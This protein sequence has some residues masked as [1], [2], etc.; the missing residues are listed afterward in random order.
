M[1]NAAEVIIRAVLVSNLG[2]L[3]RSRD[4]CWAGKDVFCLEEVVVVSGVGGVRVFVIR[5]ENVFPLQS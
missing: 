2:L 5:A 3:L 4:V 1:E